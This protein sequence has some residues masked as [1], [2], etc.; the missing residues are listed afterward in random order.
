MGKLV[1]RTVKYSLIFLSLL[2]VALLAAP[3]FI[4][5]NDYKSIIVNKVEQ[6][7]GRDVSIGDLHASLFPWVGVRMDDV[8]LANRPGFSDE[9][10]LR[11]KS[12]D[13]RLAM[14]PL[15]NRRVEIRRFVMDGP[16]LLLERDADGTGNWEDLLPEAKGVPKAKIG[17]PQA[18]GG[19]SG[20]AAPATPRRVDN[21]GVSAA[22]G[23]IPRKSIPGRENI[24][25]ALSANSLRMLNGKVHYRDMQSGRDITLSEFGVEM[26]DVQ[27]KRPVHMHVSGKLSGD[28]FSLNA[29]VGPLGNLS[30][31]SADKLPLQAN[32]KAKSIALKHIAAFIPALTGLAQGALGV[33]ARI[34]Q[35]PD[36]L[37]VAAGTLTWHG[38]HEVESGWKLEM[39]K[40]D[41]LKLEHLSIRA[42]GE[43]LADISGS[44]RDIGRKAQYQLRINTPAISRDR[45]SSWIP[46]LRTM[47]AAHPAPWEQVRLGLLAAG[48]INH[49]ELRDVQMVLDKELVQASGNIRFGAA[50]RARLRI[51]ARAF[52]ADPW[53]PKPEKSNSV[54]TSELQIIPQARAEDVEIGQARIGK[55]QMDMGGARIIRT[56]P[57]RGDIQQ[58]SGA[59]TGHRPPARQPAGQTIQGNEGAAQQPAKYRL[60]GAATSTEPDLRFLKPWHVAIGLQVDHLF[61]HGLDLGHLQATISGKGG[62]FNLDPLRFE[63]AGGQVSEKASLTVSRYPVRWSES[64]DIH[65][66]QVQPVL[67]AL[68][69]TDILKGVMQMET[70]LHGIGLLPD[71]AAGSL[72]GK[73]NVLLRDG[74]VKGFD[75]AGT[76]RNVMTFG[77]RSGPRHTDFSQLSGSFKVRNGIVK[78]DDLFMASPLFRLTG[79]GE[80][81]LRNKSMDYHVKP[82]LVGTLAGQGDTET[83]RKGLVIP[84]RITGPLDAPRVKVEM[85]LKTLIGNAGSIKGLIRGKGGLK[86]ILQGVLKGNAPDAVGPASSSPPA[87]SPPPDNPVERMRKRLKQLLPGF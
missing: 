57:A 4:N 20:P 29:E 69:D 66:V 17:K 28:A 87:A 40:A 23:A 84:L 58:G 85:N 14:L 65:G 59:G 27:L 82:R 8:R 76:L 67:I 42:D 31:L 44:V 55:L 78:N 32:I 50:P 56:Q 5:V 64:V 11:V 48:D 68:A 38:V 12:L 72:A 52:H 6:A 62:R 15:L 43:K 86:G 30:G 37:R 75:I 73:G 61:L 71:A 16:K 13:V 7:T 51:T 83:A 54:N 18:P 60:A 21:R 79:Y 26:D 10:F 1:K 3:F 39:P 35:R 46:D 9:N 33:D 63:L 49:V 77:Q 47:Y 34:E 25:A 36:G 22:P 24:L 74:M 45:L 70:K 81:N 41:R 80:V 19:A 53:L 2:I